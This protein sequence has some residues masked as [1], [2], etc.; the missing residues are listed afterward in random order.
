MVEK[1]LA[2][3]IYTSLRDPILPWMEVRDLVE[4]AFQRA[5]L[6]LVQNRDLLV[7]AVRRLLEKET[8]S[9]GEL[10][11]VLGKVAGEAPRAA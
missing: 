1:L 7:E 11:E 5:R 4:A 3:G 8:L 9:D 2:V 10:A 6:L